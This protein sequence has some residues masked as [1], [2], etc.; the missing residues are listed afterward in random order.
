MLQCSCWDGDVEYLACLGAASACCCCC[1]LLLLLLAAAA[2]CSGGEKA[3]PLQ[4]DELAPPP[5]QTLFFSA[6]WPKEV[7]AI[8]RQ[9]CK[10]DPVRIFVGTVQVNVMTKKICHDGMLWLMWNRCLMASGCG[11][12][13]TFVAFDLFVVCHHC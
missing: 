1:C 8:A 2:A 3:L 4:P 5:R 7:R 12:N 11:A 9:L 6:T 10:I 13:M